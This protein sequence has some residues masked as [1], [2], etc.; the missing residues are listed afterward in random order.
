MSQQLGASPGIFTS[1]I[2]WLKLKNYQ[3]EVTVALY[4]LTPTEKFVFNTLLLLI[5]SMLLIAAY[6]YLPDH[7]TTI[8]QRIWYYWAGDAFA[9]DFSFLSM[10][11][12][13]SSSTAAAVLGKGGEVLME[14]ARKVAGTAATT[15]AEA[16]GKGE[17]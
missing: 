3:Y 13:A 8:C 10:A 11:S 6:V 15:A 2:R 14:T 9:S 1:F 16:V 12:S 4:M 5:T 7:I 17:L